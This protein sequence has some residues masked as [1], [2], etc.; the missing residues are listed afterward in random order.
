MVVSGHPK[1]RITNSRESQLVPNFI[2]NLLSCRSCDLCLFV[3]NS[4]KTSVVVLIHH[5]LFS[6]SHSEK[7]SRTSRNVC[8]RMMNEEKNAEMSR[9]LW[10]LLKNSDFNMKW[11]FE[12]WRLYMCMWICLV[13]SDFYHR[14]T[15][16][17]LISGS[18][19]ISAA[20]NNN[21][22][23]LYY[24][25]NSPRPRHAYTKHKNMLENLS[26]NYH[27]FIRISRCFNGRQ[28]WAMIIEFNCKKKL[29][30]NLQQP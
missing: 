28:A 2:K 22:K 5:H 19:E 15:Q 25:D 1:A 16:C 24:F 18:C 12:V 30:Q 4:E 7:I 3:C 9:L 17:S 26:C 20:T 23:S 11:A 10:N 6:S 8:R 21:M 29:H 27:N 14:P 13:Q